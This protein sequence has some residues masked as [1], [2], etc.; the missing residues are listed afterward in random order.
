MRARSPSSMPAL[1]LSSA[2]SAGS[3]TKRSLTRAAEGFAGDDI[4]K[5]ALIGCSEGRL[6]GVVEQQHRRFGGTGS[7]RQ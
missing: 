2:R 6:V 1:A 3:F 5:T 7:T 4:E